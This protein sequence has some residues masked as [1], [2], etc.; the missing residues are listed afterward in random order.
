MIEELGKMFKNTETVVE[1]ELPK[2]DE[3]LN[4]FDSLLK[5]LKSNSD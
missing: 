3:K 1:A 2:L 5:E 4:S